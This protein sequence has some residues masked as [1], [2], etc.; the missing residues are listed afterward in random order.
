LSGDDPSHV[1][2]LILNADPS[3]YDPASRENSSVARR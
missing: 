1:V 2:L 3:P